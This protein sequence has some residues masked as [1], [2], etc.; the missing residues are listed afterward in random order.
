MRKFAAL[1]GLAGLAA[2]AVCNPGSATAQAPVKASEVATS[3][4]IKV[5]P[6]DG[7]CRILLIDRRQLASDIPGVISFVEPREGDSVEKGEL[8]AKLR[9]EVVTAE[10]AVAEKKA[11][12][13]VAIEHA[14][15]AHAFSEVEYAKQRVLFSQMATTSLEVE[16][17]KVIAERSRLEVKQ[18]ELQQELDALARD[19]VRARLSIYHIQAPFDGV[20]TNVYKYP[21]EA[22]RQGD[23]ILEIVS[24]DRVRVEGYI[25]VPEAV[26]V[27]QGMLAE[28][29]VANLDP[30]NPL[31]TQ[32]FQGKVVFVDP[33]VSLPGV[34]VWAEIPN[35]DGAL[36][37]GL[38]AYMTI[39]TNKMAEPEKTAKLDR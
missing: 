18:A 19:E 15:A 27:R 25:P 21:G 16:R 5:D 23:P 30:D 12:S 6:K 10:L 37:E 32:T 28:V 26:R 14:R 2:A 7:I 34:K 39:H 33:T 31:A 36:R 1:L 38:A 17:T 20:V 22:I 4:T 3:D 24:T 8:V 11:A 9:D 13:D 29:R 35:P